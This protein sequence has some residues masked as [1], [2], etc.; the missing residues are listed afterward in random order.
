MEDELLL[1]V[2]HIYNLIPSQ[3]TILAI[4]AS[5]KTLRLAV[6]REPNDPS[7]TQPSVAVEGCGTSANGSYSIGYVTIFPNDDGDPTSDTDCRENQG[8][9]DPNRKDGFP[10]GYG[11]SH[12][13]FPE[14]EIEFLIQFQNT[15]SD[16]A[17]TVVLRDTLDKWLDISTFKLGA[18]S[19][20][21]STEMLGPNVLKFTFSNIQLPD[22][23]TNEMRSHGFLSFKIK[24]K[25]NTPLSTKIKNKAAI[26]FDFNA[27]V[28]TNQTTHK[29][30]TGFIQLAPVSTENPIEKLK[31]QLLKISPNPI[32]EIAIIDFSNLH[33]SNGFIKISNSEGQVL[34]TENA[35]GS[36]FLVEKKSLSSGFYWVEL[37]ENQRVVAVGRVVF[38]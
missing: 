18:A 10:R 7:G 14:T 31:I 8:S 9:F 30:D 20:L 36:T 25:S 37:I 22:S 35:S 29:V 3:D 16:T 17:F 5:G 4:A 21:F 12:F 2:G 33:F 32:S 11:E 23:S 27:P 6:K 13:I 26:Y 34:R 38:Q 1:R 19:H 28:L 24:P 15:G